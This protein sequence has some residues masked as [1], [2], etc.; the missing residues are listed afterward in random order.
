MVGLS[1]CLVT[2]GHCSSPAPGRQVWSVDTLST[3]SHCSGDAVRLRSG[4]KT[5]RTS[6][7]SD[8]CCIMLTD[9]GKGGKKE[10][11]K[12]RKKDKEKKK[13]K[14]GQSKKKKKKDVCVCGGGGGGGEKEEPTGLQSFHALPNAHFLD[15]TL[16]GCLTDLTNIM[17]KHY[18]ST[19]YTQTTKDR[20]LKKSI[21]YT[22][23]QS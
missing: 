2:S 1:Q 15:G 6:R 8:R 5:H 17:L 4:L 22:C 16:K 11:K 23:F 20:G 3:V 10:K 7:G 13:K 14:E 12:R 21:I 19:N 18:M 9:R